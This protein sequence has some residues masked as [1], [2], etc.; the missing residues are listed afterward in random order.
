MLL[1][2]QNKK[3]QFFVIIIRFCGLKTPSG[4]KKLKNLKIHSYT[5]TPHEVCDINNNQN[6][7]YVIIKV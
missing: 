5:S 2:F 7:Q 1:T 6:I 4:F 3:G